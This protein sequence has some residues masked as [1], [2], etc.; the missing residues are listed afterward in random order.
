MLFVEAV[1]ISTAKLGNIATFTNKW[2]THIKEKN[3]N[4]NWK[5]GQLLV[6]AN[7][8]FM[9]QL[10]LRVTYFIVALQSHDTFNSE[11]GPNLL[12]SQNVSS[13]GAAAKAEGGERRQADA[14]KHASDILALQTLRRGSVSHSDCPAL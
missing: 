4:K 3:R 5:S 1:S 6:K 13:P 10:S 11:V 12:Q 7:F 8:D 14:Y 9:V 2:G